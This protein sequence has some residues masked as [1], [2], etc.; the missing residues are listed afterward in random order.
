MESPMLFIRIGN[1][2]A[3]WLKIVFIELR[4][5]PAIPGIMDKDSL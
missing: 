1:Y 4:W 3:E 2:N 5:G